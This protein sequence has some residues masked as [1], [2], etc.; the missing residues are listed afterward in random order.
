MNSKE[1]NLAIKIMST[2]GKNQT[3]NSFDGN[4]NTLYSEILK[5]QLQKTKK[6]SKNSILNIK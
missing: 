4:S 2:Y 6:S 3:L 5:L 1:L